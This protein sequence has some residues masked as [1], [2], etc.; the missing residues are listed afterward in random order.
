MNTPIIRERSI[1]GI[2]ASPDTKLRPLQVQM[3]AEDGG[4]AKPKPEQPQEE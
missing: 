2:S 4:K 3:I 1:K